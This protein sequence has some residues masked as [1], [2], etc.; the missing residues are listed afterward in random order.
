MIREPSYGHELREE[1]V[2]VRELPSAL[3]FFFSPEHK[4]QFAS[5]APTLLSFYTSS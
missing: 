1:Y 5:P 4:Q 3:F 2:E